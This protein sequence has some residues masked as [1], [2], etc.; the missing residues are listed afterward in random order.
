MFDIGFWELTIIAVIAL[1]VLGPERL[2]GLARTAGMWFSKLRR[3]VSN[4]KADID[5]ELKAEEIRRA[6]EKE[7]GIGE[8]KDVLDSTK[9]TLDQRI[10]E[11]DYIVKAIDD[12][13]TAAPTATPA[14]DETP[15]A[16][17]PTEPAQSDTSTSA[18]EQKQR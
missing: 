8:L 17:P 14:K 6:L 7:A 13:P 12:E 16:T 2:P 10:G 9:S 15:T 5:K 18:D 1:I 4:V 3:F 11:K